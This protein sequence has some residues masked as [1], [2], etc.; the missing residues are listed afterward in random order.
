MFCFYRYSQSID[1]FDV[2][3]KK[4]LNNYIYLTKARRIKHTL[5]KKNGWLYHCTL[6]NVHTCLAM[7]TAKMIG[8]KNIILQK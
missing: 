1:E 6:Y 3:T 8:V 2:A 4:I 5:F 7:Q